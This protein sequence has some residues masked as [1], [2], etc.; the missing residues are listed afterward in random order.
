MKKTGIDFFCGLGGFGLAMRKAGITPVLAADIW[1]A[2]VENYPK[3]FPSTKAVQADIT[4][5]KFQRWVLQNYSGSVHC[6]TGGPPC[7][8]FST[9]NNDST[10]RVGSNLPREFV[11]LATKLRPAVI[12][13]EEVPNFVRLKDGAFYR[14]VLHEAKRANYVVTFEGVVDSHEFGSYQKR[15]RY[16]LRLEPKKGPQSPPRKVPARCGSKPKTLGDVVAKTDGV[17]LKPTQIQTM[18][19]M[20]ALYKHQKPKFNLYYRKLRLDRPSPTILGN[21]YTPGA[22]GFYSVG[23][24]H[25]TLSLKQGLLIQG[26]PVTWKLPPSRADAALAI[27]NSVVSDVAASVLNAVPSKM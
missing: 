13:M 8:A 20:T 7:Q 21:F 19:R 17:P 15:R 11:K 6:V 16:F 26:F 2:A 18:R 24:K 3:N 1:A 12:V 23:T 5:P 14:D 25:Y 9:N 27:A 10:K 22:F 4:D